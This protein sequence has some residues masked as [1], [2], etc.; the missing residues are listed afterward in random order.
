M[1]L[2][3]RLFAALREGCGCDQ[4]SIDW[5]GPGTA[6]QVKQAVIALH[7]ELADL[8]LVSRVAVNHTFVAD[9]CAI[10]LGPPTQSPLEIALIPPVSGG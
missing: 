2:H 8:I 5:S 7:P 4:I 6:A 1:K 10:E 9:A 3:V